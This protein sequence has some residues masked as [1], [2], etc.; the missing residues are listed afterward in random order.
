MRLMNSLNSKRAGGFSRFKG[1]HAKG[2]FGNQPRF[3]AKKDA[4][5]IVRPNQKYRG[6][7]AACQKKCEALFIPTPAKPLYCTE[8]F[9]Q[10]LGT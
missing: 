4:M 7:C 3:A 6:V 8:C 10:G 1:T 5:K 2:V 9:A